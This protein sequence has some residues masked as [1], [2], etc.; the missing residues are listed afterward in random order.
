LVI[1]RYNQTWEVLKKRKA[2]KVRGGEDQTLIEGEIV[3]ACFFKQ[4][5][6][7]LPL[8]KKDKE[9]P[10]TRTVRETW[11]SVPFNCTCRGGEGKEWFFKTR[12]VR[13]TPH[14]LVREKKLAQTREGGESC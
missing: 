12:F 4:T 14:M 9:P 13:D 5:M 7:P 6:L 11:I 1:K 2:S 3:K 10:L 8:G